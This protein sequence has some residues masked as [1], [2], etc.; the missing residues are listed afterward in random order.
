MLGWLALVWLCLLAD[1]ITSA[2]VLGWPRWRRSG[3]VETFLLRRCAQLRNALAAISA[4]RDET[5]A[6]ANALENDLEYAAERLRAVLE[7]M[8]DS[9]ANREAAHEIDRLIDELEGVY[10]SPARAA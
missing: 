5:Q 8:G 1:I 10:S 3:L 7:L 2:M 9:D 4:E 6:D